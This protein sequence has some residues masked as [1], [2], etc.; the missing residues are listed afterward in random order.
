MANEQR[1]FRFGVQVN[2]TGDRQEWADLARRVEANG[3][4]TLTMPDHFNDQ[5]A[6][7]PALQAAADATTTLRLGALVYDNDYKHPVVLAKELATM[8][9]LSDGRVEIGLGAGWMISDYE[10]SGIPYDRPGVRVSRM[11]EGLAVIKGALGPGP[12]SFAGEHY[13]ITDYDGTPAPM[14]SPPPVLIGGGGP[15]VLRFA[16]READ[17]VGINATLTS[18]AVDQS[19]FESMTAEATDAKVQIVRDAATEAGR[20]ADIEMNIRAFMVFVTDDPDQGLET[21]A[22]FTGAP[23]EVIAAS[24]FALVGPASKIIDELQERRQRWGF[25]YVIVGQNDIE[26]FAPVVAALAGT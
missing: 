15:R 19:T 24:P 7:V 11:I 14:Q 25:S 6:P 5:L 12:F 16:A 10:Q 22:G 21:L 9:V 4:A 8:D 26:P 20:L 18:G 23:K 1:P 3:Y 17:I 13:T 2:G